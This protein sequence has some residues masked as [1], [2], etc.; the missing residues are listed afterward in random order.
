MN[1]KYARLASEH[2]TQEIKKWNRTKEDDKKKFTNE[3]LANNKDHFLKCYDDF[4]NDYRQDKLNKAQ[5]QYEDKILIYEEA[6]YMKCV[7]GYDNQV[8]TGP[9]WEFIGCK[10]YRD[11]SYY[12]TKIYKPHLPSNKNMNI[13]MSS[14]FMDHL[15]ILNNLPNALKVS[16]LYDF[17]KMNNRELYAVDLRTIAKS[18]TDSERREEMVKEILMTKFNKVNSQKH[19]YYKLEN[20]SKETYCIPDFICSNNN[21]IYIIEQKKGAGNINTQQT[22][23][24]KACVEYICKVHKITLPIKIAYIVEFE[25]EYMNKD[26]NIIPFSK[27]LEYQFD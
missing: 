5:R 11:N 12:H 19:I 6:K 2:E 22:E 7:C 10:N 26:L 14:I 21:S 20:S 23:L 25:D 15:K 4:P 8:I 27:L 9:D 13:E 18:K 1:I 3:W 16:I 17:V 24:Y